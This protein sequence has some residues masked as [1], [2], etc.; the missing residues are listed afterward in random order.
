MRTT[1]VHDNPEVLIFHDMLYD[2]EINTLKELATP[3]VSCF[4][5]HFISSWF[6]FG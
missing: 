5:S 3:Y 4:W 1:R 2:E 6:Y